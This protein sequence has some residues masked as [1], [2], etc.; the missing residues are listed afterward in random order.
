MTILIAPATSRT[1]SYVINALLA[2]EPN[3]SLRLLAHSSDS[4]VKLKEKY[5]AYSSVHTVVADFMNPA[6]L[7][8]AM[9]NVEALFL[10]LP[11]SQNSVQV[12]KNAIDA[13]KKK[14]V[15]RAVFCSV[16]HPFIQGMRHH[17][18]KL[19]CVFS[20]YCCCAPL[21]NLGHHS[22]ISGTSVEEYLFE[23]GLNYTILEVRLFRFFRQ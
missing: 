5:K 14:M 19:E 16:L 4:E 8:S 17:R 9:A 11:L 21:T 15:E 10:N 20:F 3:A 13:A 2:L 18:Q 12:G 22:L 6:T 1:N 7:E 23:S